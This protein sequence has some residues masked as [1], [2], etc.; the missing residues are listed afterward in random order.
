MNTPVSQALN[1]ICPYFT[2]FP[3]KFP[4]DV[5]RRH[6]V[7]SDWVLDPFCGRGTTN[8]AAR[9]LGLPSVGIDSSPVAVALTEAKLARTTSGEIIAY[10]QRILSSSESALDIPQGEFWRWAFEATVLQSICRLREALLCDC[11]S[12]AHKALRA[13]MLGALHGPRTKSVASHLSNQCPRTY[14][15]KPRYAVKYWQARDLK[16]P[17]I[18]VAEV[19]RARAERYYPES[20]LATALPVRGMVIAADSRDGSAFQAVGPRRVR[21]I[22]TSPP[23]YGMR[24]YVPD[25]WLRNWFVGGSSEVDY[26]NDGQLSHGSPE[27]FASQLRSVWQN[28]ASVATPD[29]RLVVRMGGIADRRADPLKILKASLNGSNW[30]L[31]TLK[32]AGTSEAGRRQSIHF[33][34]TRNTPKVEYDVWAKLGC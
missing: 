4:F 19:I 15:P 5:L 33:G 14:A 17:R 1:A 27:S 34:T 26:S 2:M 30:V 3:L 24:T 7:E 6:A 22:V 25:Q 32:P 9:L 10:A 31:V 29:A 16:P 28:A 11:E 20:V 23:Y 8:Y 21:W 12:E 13:I 18:D